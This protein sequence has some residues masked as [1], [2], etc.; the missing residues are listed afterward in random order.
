MVKIKTICN[1]TN[2]EEIQKRLLK[3]FKISEDQIKNIIFVNDNSYDIL[4]VFGYI[5]EEIK[6]DSKVLLFPQE[7]TWTGGHQKTFGGIDN[8]KVFGF[9]KQNYSPSEVV[10]ETIAHMFYGG[11]GSQ[12]EG[13]DFWNYDFLTNNQFIKTKDF[14]SFVS[15]RGSN[16]GSHPTGCLYG[17][18]VNL[19]KNIHNKVLY[20]DFYG[21]GDSFNL[22]PFVLKKS[23]TIKDYKFCLTIENSH[24][25]YYISEKFYDCILTNTVPIYFGCKNIKEYWPENGYFL[26]ENI[27]DYEYVIEK[28]NWIYTH[29]DELYYEMLP[30]LIKMKK[31]YFKEFNLIEK[32]K[33]E[34]NIN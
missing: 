24:E 14:C 15:N 13:Y 18:R 21:W 12:E 23:E 26:L 27:T 7:P 1:W 25:N 4:V 22:K 31:R 3:E 2:N 30:E 10:T 32:I 19:I 34:G 6:K 11:R 33:K 17:E 5:N 9:D 16:E 29:K 28:L 20:M 8:I